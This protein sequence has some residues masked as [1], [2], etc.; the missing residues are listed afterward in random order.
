MS[1]SLCLRIDA[2][3]RPLIFPLTTA[4][5]LPY[6]H[7]YGSPIKILKA[8]AS[9]DRGTLRALHWE[10]F[11]G[12]TFQAGVPPRNS[13]PGAE[14]EFDKSEKIMGDI[15]LCGTEVHS[16]RDPLGARVSYIHFKTTHG[17]EFDIGFPQT[18]AKY[19]FDSG[20]SH[21]MGFFGRATS[22]LICL[23]FYMMKPIGR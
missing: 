7:R 13:A 4:Y 8:W 18:Q 9:D 17:K 15:T 16:S 3:E 5:N 21:L 6:S 2:A 19:T 20:D 10:H 23:G 14:I 1:L 22:E 11:D 12:T